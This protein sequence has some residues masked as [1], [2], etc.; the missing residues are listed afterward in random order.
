MLIVF[1]YIFIAGYVYHFIDAYIGRIDSV[2][3]KIGISLLWPL[4][5]IAYLIFGLV[6]CGYYLK[7]RATDTKRID[8][9]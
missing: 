5:A 3:I 9:E 8:L 6:L 2:K 4:L 1:V 7:D